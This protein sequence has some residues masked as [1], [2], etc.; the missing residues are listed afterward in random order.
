MLAKSKSDV[1]VTPLPR[2]NVGIQGN[3]RIEKMGTEEMDF[4]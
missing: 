2:T 3:T 4:R 1:F